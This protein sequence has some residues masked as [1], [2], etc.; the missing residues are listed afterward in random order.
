MSRLTI[1]IAASYGSLGVALGAYRAH[2]LEK[3]LVAAQ[4]PAAEITQRLANLGI[5]VEYGLIHAVAL[6]A[7]TALGTRAS[8]RYLT[9]AAILLALGT[10]LFSGSLTL[11]ALSGQSGYWLIPPSGGLLLITGWL[12]VALHAICSARVQADSIPV[13][14]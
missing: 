12:A 7:I 5:A 4:L 9:L 2:G 3:A 8:S 14:L 10:F 13:S 11:Q 6:V 1:F